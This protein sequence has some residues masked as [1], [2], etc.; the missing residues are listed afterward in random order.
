MHEDFNRCYA[1]IQSKDA[2][3]DGWFVAAVR[4]TGIYCRP[5]CPARSPLAHNVAFFPTS[6]AAQQA[7][8]RA[9]KRCRPDASPSSPAWD[10][11]QDIAARAMR[12]IADGVIDR[13]GV[14]GLA[15][16]LG[17][18]TRQVERRLRAAVG[19]GPLSLARA[20]RAQT[21]RLLI[22][23]T[24]MPLS[25]VAFAAGFSSIRQFNDV[26]A[27]VFASTP[28][29]LR[30]N[31]SRKGFPHSHKNPPLAHRL[32]FRLPFRAPLAPE[33]LFGHLGATA[34]P[35][36]E[37]VCNGA[38]RRTLRLPNGNGIASLT[39][40]HDYIDCKLI[41]DDIRD[42]PVAIARCRRLLDLDA[43]PEAVGTVLSLDRA[44]APA[45]LHCPGRRIPR[46]TDG[47]E[48]ALRIVL[49][50]QVSTRA[51]RTH[52]ARI[53]ELTGT[54]IMDPVG[55]L[56]RVFPLP[57]RLLDLDPEELALPRFRRN[58]LLTLAKALANSTI[59]LGVGGN[60][61]RSLTQL[62]HI[63]GI[64][65]WTLELIAMRA[66]GNPDSFPVSDLGVIKG[67]KE[68]GLP[69]TPSALNAYSQR[70]RPWRSYAVQY[71]WGTQHHEINTWP[72]EE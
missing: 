65:P 33:S 29:E 45:V 52:T 26:V 37:E 3:F 31:A 7:G 39:P 57:E 56:N 58:T 30:Q 19:V 4:T 9:C 12:L 35:G 62:A 23:T 6:A 68:L 47:D 2:R 51:A 25:E 46:S 1:A 20:N 42:I 71:L 11:G 43:D 27:L 66:Y 69:L 64:G 54:P 61:E 50:Q 14:T 44:L 41:L 36:C 34:V 17:Y 15:S 53:V 48:M 8:F 38:F 55:N 40:R 24:A 60:Q 32:S 10:V 49:G 70:W 59:E 63:V 13:E 28:S 21:A 18:S 72:T 67:A 16:R 5:S 22:E